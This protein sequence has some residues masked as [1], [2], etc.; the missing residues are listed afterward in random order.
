M[1]CKVFGQ[2]MWP[3]W[4]P[5][6]EVLSRYWHSTSGVSNLGLEYNF[7]TGGLKDDFY[8]HYPG[9]HAIRE[10]LDSEALH[11]AENRSPSSSSSSLPTGGPRLLHFVGSNLG[12]FIDTG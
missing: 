8:E 2:E 5:E 4:C 12:G 6:E 10:A 7:E 9:Y 1:L 3:S 11:D